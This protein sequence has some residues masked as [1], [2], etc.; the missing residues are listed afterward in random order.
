MLASARLLLE[1]PGLG[2]GLQ[3]ARQVAELQA[4][5]RQLEKDY[6]ESLRWAPRSELLAEEGE[7]VARLFERFRE[8]CRKLEQYLAAPEPKILVEACD[9]VCTTIQGFQQSAARLQQQEAAWKQEYGSGLSAEIRFLV[10]Q[11]QSG[12]LSYQQAALALEKGLRGCREMLSQLAQGQPESEGVAA[13]FTDC[14]VA[15]TALSRSLERTVQCLRS[16]HSWEVDDRLEDLLQTIDSVQ[17]AYDGLMRSL[18]PPRPCLVCGQ[19]EDGRS[20]HCSQCSAR[21]PV[22]ALSVPG[23]S[24]TEN[25]LKPRLQAFAQLEIRIGLWGEGCEDEGPC[26]SQAES[27]QLRIRQGLAQMRKDPHLAP[28]VKEKLVQASQGTLLWLEDLSGAL[29]VDARGRASSLIDSLYHWEEQMVVAAQAE[30]TPGQ[31]P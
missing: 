20:S 5:R 12:Q 17:I 30:S 28:E 11:A 8:G 29:A 15:L 27:F 23:A 22:Q 24:P 31:T 2:E 16:Q 6:R 14:T 1:N 10:A 25:G 4:F 21:L 9:S 7:K 3:F 19:L 18:F 26:R 13:A